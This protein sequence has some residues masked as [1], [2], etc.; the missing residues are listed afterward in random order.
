M[1]LGFQPQISH[2]LPC[3]SGVVLLLSRLSVST[4]KTSH[5]RELLG[6]TAVPSKFMSLSPTGLHIP[7]PDTPSATQCFCSNHS[8]SHTNDDSLSYIHTVPCF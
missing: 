8:N 3:G 7:I 5:M 1:R 6:T 2:Q 4:C